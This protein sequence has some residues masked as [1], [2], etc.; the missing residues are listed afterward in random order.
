MIELTLTLLALLGISILNGSTLGS[1]L[2]AS[3]MAL[4]F[5]IA[6]AWQAIK[7]RSRAKEYV[8][9]TAA[10]LGVIALLFGLNAANKRAGRTGVEKIAVACESYKAKTGAYPSSLDQLVPE[11]LGHLPVAKYS[12]WWSRYWLSDNR[13]MFA[14]EPGLLVS[15]YDLASK[16]WGAAGMYKV[17][18]KR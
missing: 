3:V 2:A 8:W 1:F 11:Q 4:V 5:A 14:V 7:G 13:V 10:C 16:E 12:L 18:E 6:S 15:F 9:K 17:L